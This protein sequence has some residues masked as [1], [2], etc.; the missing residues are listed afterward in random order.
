MLNLVRPRYF[1]PVHGEYRHLVRHLAARARGR[2]AGRRLSSARGRRRA[3]DRRRRRRAR[4]SACRPGASSS[5]ARASATSGDV[6]LRD[7]RHLS[8][9][10]LVLAV[11]A[12]EQQSGE[13]VAGPD[14]VSRGVVAEEASPEVFEGAREVVL[15]ALDGHQPGVAHRSRRGQGGG[16]QGACVA[17]SSAGPPAGDPPLRPGDVVDAGG[18][19]GGGVMAGRRQQVGERRRLGGTAPPARGGG[20]ARRSRRRSSWRSRSCPTAPDLPRQNLGGP[21]GH[22]LAD[23]GAARARRRGVPLPG[24][25]RL[26][27][28]RAAARATA[29]TSAARGS[30]ARCCSSAASRPLAGLRRGRQGDRC[31]AAAGWAASSARR[32]AVWS[33]ARAPIS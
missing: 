29:T 11:L 1:V 5:T 6:V 28:G 23:T 12:I 4:A 25:P 15:E 10:G 13:I 9:D 24:L 32:S 8:E 20:A 2:R 14:L 33:A 26:R 3:R 31:A 7:R 17:I 19:C 22:R 16:P 30:A 21:V 18:G 27:R